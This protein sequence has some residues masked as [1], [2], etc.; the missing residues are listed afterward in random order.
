MREHN[1]PLQLDARGR[2]NFTDQG[3]LHPMTPITQ[4]LGQI[5]LTLG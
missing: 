2:V 3:N 1:M 5:R 4:N